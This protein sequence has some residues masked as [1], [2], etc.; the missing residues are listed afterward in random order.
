MNSFAIIIKMS[1][2]LF[3]GMSVVALDFGFDMVLGFDF[4]SAICFVRTDGFRLV[5]CN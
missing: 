1:M 5:L 2:K 4:F 3:A